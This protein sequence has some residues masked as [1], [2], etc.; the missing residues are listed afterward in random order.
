MLLRFAPFVSLLL[1]GCSI[2]REGPPPDEPLWVVYVLSPID[3][4]YS[5]EHYNEFGAGGGLRVPDGPFTYEGTGTFREVATIRP[6][7]GLDSS[8]QEIRGSFSGAYLVV[9]FGTR[10]Y[11]PGGSAIGQG[12][13]SGSLQRVSGPEPEVA[14]C[15]VRYGP[16]GP[17]GS[18]YRLHFRLTLDAS[19]VC[20]QP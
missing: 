1:A 15:S 17:E 8:L 13:E 14:S 11:R 4:S 16:S 5:I 18:I 9:G 2:V 19:S 7:Q 10:T 20:R 12:A 6:L 3:G